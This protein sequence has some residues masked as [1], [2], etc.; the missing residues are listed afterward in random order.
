MNQTSE[1]RI[2]C[3]DRFQKRFSISEYKTQD[4]AMYQNNLQQHESSLQQQQQN[5]LAQFQQQHLQHQQQ[6][7]HILT[8]HQQQQQHQNARGNFFGQR[9][10]CNSLATQENSIHKDDIQQQQTNQNSLQQ[11]HHGTCNSFQQQQYSQNS[12][13]QKPE[14]YANNFHST[15]N[16]IDSQNS[17]EH[18]AAVQAEKGK[19]YQDA[20]SVKNADGYENLNGN[21]QNAD[22]GLGSQDVNIYPW[23]SSRCSKS[24]NQ[25]MRYLFCVYV[26]L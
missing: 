9:N 20:V 17:F 5:S 26:I 15:N 7:Q 2:A 10:S 12:I 14:N 22:P 21:N 4:S 6:Q 25:L 3:N 23:R 1:N 24:I 16:I 18:Q 13:L 19:E 8:N 11:Q